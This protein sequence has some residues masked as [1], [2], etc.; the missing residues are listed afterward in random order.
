MVVRLFFGGVVGKRL[1]II[2]QG[3]FHGDGFLVFVADNIGRV[4][5]E[6]LLD[7]SIYRALIL[8]FSVHALV[9]LIVRRG[10]RKRQLDQYRLAAGVA[11]QVKILRQ[12]L[13][14]LLLKGVKKPIAS[15]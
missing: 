10:L 9:V 12:L 11:I 14:A 6:L 4:P 5:V 15:H 8:K 3:T 2:L 7:Q 1:H 13:F